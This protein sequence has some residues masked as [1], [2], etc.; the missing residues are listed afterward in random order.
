MLLKL[1]FWAIIL[2][3]VWAKLEIQI[4]GKDGWAK[5]LPTWKIKNRFTDFV[6]SG[7]PLTG[8]HFWIITLLLLSFHLP[9]FIGVPWSF[10]IEI[11]LI[12]IFLIFLIVED[13]LWFLLNPYYGIRKFNQENIP[14]HK[15]WLGPIPIAYIVCCTLGTILIL[16]SN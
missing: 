15:K 9:F 11:G 6:L 8:F 16:A 7:S 10:K 4:E 2:A 3:F 5:N 14:W 12:G 1:A 13:F